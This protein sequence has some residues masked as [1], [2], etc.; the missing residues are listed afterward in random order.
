MKSMASDLR[1]GR[2]PGRPDGV[3]NRASIWREQ[4]VSDTGQ[5]PLEFMLAIMRDDGH[6]V[7]FRFE[8]AKA[9]A[10]YVHAKYQAI[11]IKASIEVN[12]NLIGNDSEATR[13]MA[14][15]LERTDTDISGLAMLAKP[16]ID[17]VSDD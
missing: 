14:L 4:R 12:G 15:L 2:P 5:T 17:V 7:I 10:P 13:R 11:A 3:R 1:L 16:V 9:A 6:G 8:A